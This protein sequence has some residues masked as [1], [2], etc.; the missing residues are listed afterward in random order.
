MRP[1]CRLRR[2][3]CKNCQ[4][5][6]FQALNSGWVIIVLAGCTTVYGP[7]GPTGGYI[8]T[9]LADDTWQVEFRGNENTDAPTI[10]NFA[11]LRAAELCANDSYRYLQII[12]NEVQIRSHYYSPPVVVTT[13]DRRSANTTSMGSPSNAQVETVS[14]TSGADMVVPG[15][16]QHCHAIPWTRLVARCVNDPVADAFTMS[17]EAEPLALK[18]RI[19]YSLTEK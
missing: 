9:R 11:Q 12:E 6:T 16:R 10:A 5:W 8:D 14:T 17:A 4:D 7:M 2:S 1:H 18:L 3:L 13:P 15:G 19:Q